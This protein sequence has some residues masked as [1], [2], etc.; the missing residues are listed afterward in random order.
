MDKKA[1]I[2][3][4]NSGDYLK[5]CIV[6]ATDYKAAVEFVRVKLPNVDRVTSVRGPVPVYK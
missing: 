4:Y 2:I 5:T 3:K 6:Y 1:F